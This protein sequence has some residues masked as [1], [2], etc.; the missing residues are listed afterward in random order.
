MLKNISLKK[1]P[2]KFGFTNKNPIKPSEHLQSTAIDDI[3]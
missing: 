3:F 2:H 1:K